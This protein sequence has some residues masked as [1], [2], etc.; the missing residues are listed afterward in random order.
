MIAV[1]RV[2]GPAWKP[3]RFSAEF[4]DAG[5]DTWDPPASKPGSSPVLLVAGESLLRAFVV[6]TLGATARGLRCRQAYLELHG[7]QPQGLVQQKL[8]HFAL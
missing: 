2:G 8:T 6:R 5:W 7:G 3:R 1:V 4:R